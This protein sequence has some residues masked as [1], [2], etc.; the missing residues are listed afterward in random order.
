MI[1]VIHSGNGNGTVNLTLNLEIASANSEKEI[2]ILD[3]T[4]EDLQTA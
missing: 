4:Q 3:A 2:G 1:C